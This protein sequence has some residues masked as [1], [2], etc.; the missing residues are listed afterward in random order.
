MGRKLVGASE[1]IGI[2]WAESI[3]KQPDQRRGEKSTSKLTLRRFITTT[4]RRSCCQET[5][6]SHGK[7]REQSQLYQVCR[8][9]V[10]GPNLHQAANYRSQD[11]K[12]QEKSLAQSQLLMNRET[13]WDCSRSS[14]NKHEHWETS[15]NAAEMLDSMEMTRNLIGLVLTR[16]ALILGHTAKRLTAWHGLI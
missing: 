14:T 12:T 11:G 9:G 13:K 16:V 15:P 10:I 7:S 3:Q 1:S 2:H 4:S 8:P 5:A 6:S